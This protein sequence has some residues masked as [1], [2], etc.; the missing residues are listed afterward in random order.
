[1][2]IR[3]YDGN[4]WQ[5]QKA[6]RIYN[7]SV[8]NTAKQAWI[9]TGTQWS[10]MYPEF[11]Q[12]TTPASI[13]ATSGTSGYIGCVYTVSVG[14]WNPNDAYAPSSY[15]YQWTRSGEDIF[16][17]TGTTYTTTAADVE[18]VIG[19]RVTAINLRGS[20]PYTVSTGVTMLPHLTSINVYDATV[21]PTAPSSVSV[22]ATNLNYSGTWTAGAN[23][24]TY[25]GFATGTAGTPSFS[26]GSRF[27]S[28]T[29]T[30]GTA[31]FYI[32]SVNTNKQVYVGWTVSPGAASYD[33]WIDSQFFVN[34]PQGANNYYFQGLADSNARTY[35]V[36]PRSTN[37]RGYGLQFGSS[38]AASDKY[39]GYTLGSVNLT[40]PNATSPTF[41]NG[42][43]STSN[44]SVSWGGSNNATKYRA[45]W[46]TASSI[47]LDPNSSYDLETT[48]TS[49]NFSGSFTEGNTY[50]F[51]ISASGANNVWTPYGSFKASGT[52]AYTA[53]GTPSPSTSSVTSSSFSIS[54][55]AVSGANSYSV[56]VGTS[57]G[58]AN[59][60]NTSGITDTSYGVTGLSASSTYYVTITAYKNGYGYGSAGYSSA[61]TLA[62]PP[63]IYSAPTLQF[64]R[65]ATQIKWGFDN[66]YFDG[67][68]DPIG[69]EWEV[70]TGQGTGTVITSGN[71]RTYSTGTSG[72]TVN[73][74]TWNYVVRSTADLPYSASPR[75]LRC[76]LYGFNTNT[77]AVF[78]GPWS[79]WA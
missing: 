37:L 9:Y 46:T 44:L 50:Y 75:Y 23:A 54:W 41:A 36:Y 38:V 60:V 30:E 59:I 22:N 20:T 14:V 33:I 15:S 72:I 55:P 8:W 45:Y 2:G 24:T 18:K 56:A 53:P 34:I 51:Y 11:P 48:S 26:F 77:Y 27:V 74:Y 10:L 21:T 31:N 58:G 61:T 64:E 69:I 65:T 57:F 63:Q 39:S 76:R 42:S 6:L 32:R 68:F 7:G 28:G 12:N 4:T 3:A 1:M 67:A 52:V 70:R 19:C 79:D 43:A 62:S 16:G 73:G 25:D 71:T 66:P 49:A 17:Q 40:P 78:N 13:S 35:Q 47:S 29:G 5:L